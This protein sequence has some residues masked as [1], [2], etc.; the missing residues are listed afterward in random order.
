MSNVLSFDA[1]VARE[2][3]EKEAKKVQRVNQKLRLEM[4]KER[5]R[6]M[7]EIVSTVEQLEI[8]DQRPNRTKNL[9]K[10]DEKEEKEKWKLALEKIRKSK[11]STN[12]FENA[13][14][15]AE[16]PLFQKSQSA[17]DIESSVRP[18]SQP[19]PIGLPR[20]QSDRILR[21]QTSDETMRKKKEAEQQ[22][23]VDYTLEKVNSTFEN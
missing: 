23:P 17:V 1:L 16:Q 14:P 10:F 4:E 20:S 11:S 7:H 5:L 2:K 8:P 21:P 13:E 19:T 12:M 22:L 3:G 18:V 9:V 15:N 6:E